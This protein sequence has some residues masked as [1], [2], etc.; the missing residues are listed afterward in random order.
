MEWRSR[1]LLPRSVCATGARQA[2]RRIC[3]GGVT[4]TL[5][6]CVWWLVDVTRPVWTHGSII[7]AF[8]PMA[9]HR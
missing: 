9:L 6:A 5:R 1:R 4:H 3:V 2:S 8:G 7:N